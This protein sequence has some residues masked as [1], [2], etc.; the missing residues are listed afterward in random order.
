M[1]PRWSRTADSILTFIPPPGSHYYVMRQSYLF[2]E[3]RSAQVDAGE[4][5][6]VVRYE[7]KVG[8]CVSDMNVISPWVFPLTYV[9]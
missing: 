7:T 3:V 1:P 4:G 5:G 6:G 9:Q 8:K 2:P